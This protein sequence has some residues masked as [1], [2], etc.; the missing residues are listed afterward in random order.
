MGTG[1]KAL[2]GLGAVAVAYLVFREMAPPPPGKAILTVDTEPVKAAVYLNGVLQDVAPLT[3]EL[4]P[5]D[6]AVGFGEVEGYIAPGTTVVTL[7]EGD[8]VTLMGTYEPLPPALT[9]VTTP[10]DAMV[11]VEG[12]EY[13]STAMAPVT[14]ED[15]DPGEYTI[16]FHDMEGYSTPSPIVVT[17]NMGDVVT[18]TGTYQSTTLPYCCWVCGECFATFMELMEHMIANHPEAWG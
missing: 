10:I 12:T 1:E 18:V 5:G 17:L 14:I 8:T 4:D 9:V 7:E 6:Y 2:L 16:T 13:S 15:L 11:T 3:L